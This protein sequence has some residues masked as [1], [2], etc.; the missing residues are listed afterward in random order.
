L[1]EPH[2]DEVAYH[3][4]HGISIR[5]AV[6]VDLPTTPPSRKFGAG[7]R[8]PRVSPLQRGR[9]IKR[10][11]EGA[12]NETHISAIDRQYRRPIDPG[13]DPTALLRFRLHPLS[14]RPVIGLLLFSASPPA[15]Q[16]NRGRLSSH[17]PLRGLL[18]NLPAQIAGAANTIP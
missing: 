14:F 12:L 9:S 4:E 1:Y 10:E 15:R 17:L 5:S 8:V 18:F 11:H 13:Q 16:L 7:R 2:H 3:S 6:R